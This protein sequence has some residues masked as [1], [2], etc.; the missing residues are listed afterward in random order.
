M[1]K[2][3]LRFDFETAPILKKLISA[4]RELA[5]LNGICDSL[6][7]QAVLVHTLA[8][9]EAKDSSEIENII[10]TH[11]DIYTAV[12]QPEFKEIKPATKEVLYYVDA[13]MKGLHLYKKKGVLTLSCIE[14][15]QSAIERNNA[16]I[17]KLPGTALVNDRTNEV[18]YEPPQPNEIP[19]LLGNFLEIFNNDSSWSIDPLVKMSVLHYQFESIHPFYDGNGRTG[20]ILNILYL[21]HEGLLNHPVLYL[22]RYINANKGLYYKYL[23]S[24]RD[25]DSDEA[26]EEYILFMLDGVVRTSQSTSRTVVALREEMSEYKHRIRERHPSIYSQDL[27]NTIFSYPY[28]RIKI[29]Q[30]RLGVSYLT[31]RKYLDAL[32][33][34]KLLEKKR[35]GRDSFYVNVSMMNILTGS[36]EGALKGDSFIQN[37]TFL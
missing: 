26:W 24:L 22:S 21:I 35:I 23:Q 19:D 11:A 14:E 34:D 28:T 4:H 20:R 13:I 7:N 16:G 5:H 10:T 9:Q 18:V 29:L 2:L 36:D 17:R 37:D 25:P 6:P 31:A 8:L 27:L 1:E 32:T 12:A 15:I 30:D 3:P 33:E